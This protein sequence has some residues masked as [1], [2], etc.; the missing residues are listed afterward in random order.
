M[1][2]DRFDDLYARHGAA[3]YARCCR[4]LDDHVAAEDAAQEIFLRVHRHIDSA[5]AQ[6]PD[7]AL[8][9][10]LRIATNYCLNMLRDRRR[11]PI[12]IEDLAGLAGGV[13]PEAGL[14]ARDLGRRLTLRAPEH[15]RAVA[16]SY[17]VEGWA[18]H[19]IALE[20]GISRRTVVNYLG[21]FAVLA[22]RFDAGASAPPGVCA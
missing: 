18:Q 14:A 7:E 6:G 3:V 1:N 13:C 15:I 21:A 12:P 5:P 4:L 22:R 10:M 8:R 16:W 11:R 17:H 20:L 9:W 19:E 2:I